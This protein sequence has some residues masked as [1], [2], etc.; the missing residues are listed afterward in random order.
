[1]FWR[2]F[3]KIVLKYRWA[4]LAGWAAITAFMIYQ[5]SRVKLSYEFYKTVPEDNQAYIDYEN[6]KAIFGEEGNILF[7]GVQTD[8]FFQLDFFNH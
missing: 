5:T 6:F 1:M 3:A 4:F 7:L 8:K 2:L